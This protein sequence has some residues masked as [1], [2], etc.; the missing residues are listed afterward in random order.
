[1]K[2]EAKKIIK[3]LFLGEMASLSEKDVLKWMVDNFQE[4][5]DSLKP[6][7]ILLGDVYY[8][9]YCGDC[10]FL[11]REK[12]TKKLF[13]VHGSHCSCY[14]FEWQFKPDA[15]TLDYL[16]SDKVNYRLKDAVY[17]DFFKTL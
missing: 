15:T 5:E 4:S 13:E 14:G 16:K 7:K 1:M 6:F 17:Q 10:F 12:S 9:D 2:K 8:G 3:Q 11:L